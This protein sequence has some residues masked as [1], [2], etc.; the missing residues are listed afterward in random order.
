MCRIIAATYAASASRTR[1]GSRAFARPAA[2]VS[3]GAVR[4]GIGICHLPTR[5][6]KHSDGKTGS[7]NVVGVRWRGRQ[8]SPIGTVVNV[9]MPTWANLVG[10]RCTETGRL[11]HRIAEGQLELP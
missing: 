5:A 10:L 11:A 3:I 6:R 8:H 4:R 2:S 9:D 7:E 1:T